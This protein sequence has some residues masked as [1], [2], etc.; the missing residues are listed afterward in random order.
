MDWEDGMLAHASGDND[1]VDDKG[2][3]VDVADSVVTLV[4]MGMDV[5]EDMTDVVVVVAGVVGKVLY[6]STVDVLDDSDKPAAVVEL[7]EEMLPKISNRGLLV[8]AED[9]LAE[10]VLEPKSA[11]PLVVLAILVALL[12]V[13][14]AHQGADLDNDDDDDDNKD[15]SESAG[16]GLLRGKAVSVE[17]YVVAVSETDDDT[18]VDSTD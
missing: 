12:T 2:D 16:G 10:S 7:L 14:L 13:S 18:A 4:V 9:A 3:T 5:D 11:Q 1:K 8:D 15:D 17:L 6:V